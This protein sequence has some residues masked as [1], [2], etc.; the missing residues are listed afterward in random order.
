MH[1]SSLGAFVDEFVVVKMWS[2]VGVKWVNPKIYQLFVLTHFF[3][4]AHDAVTRR[5]LGLRQV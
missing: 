3:V 1:P 2:R 4:H 5:G